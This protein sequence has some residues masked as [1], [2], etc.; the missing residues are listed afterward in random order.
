MLRRL[1]GGDGEVR[2]IVRTV[3]DLDALRS[4]QPKVAVADLE[5]VEGVALMLHDAHT[6]IHLAGGTDLP[7][8]ESY[9]R[10]NLSTAEWVLQACEDAGVRRFLYLSSAGASP[11]AR[12]PYL[13]AKGR[14]EAAVEASTIPER[15]VLRS[16]HVYGPGSAWLAA[17]RAL[18]TAPVAVVP[19]DGSAR[20]APVH[21]DDV[22]AVL[23]AADDRRT[24]VTGTFGLQG[25][26][27]LTVDSL[28]ALLAGRA[29]RPVHVPP[30]RAAR[31]ARLAR[32]ELSQPM[33]EL[34]A[35]DSVRDAP[36][37]AA[38]FGIALTPLA[39][40]LARSG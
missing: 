15:V 33:L 13:R 31:L 40:G 28:V 4:I 35:K 23:A 25:P 30:A 17:L 36:D 12:N 24:A 21:V 34:L 7:D 32:R 11:D 6:V 16:T 19:G 27:E 37:A 5:D 9:E 10:A 39:D 38:E 29:R 2:G 18:A 3:R 1:A 14:A 8:A 22:T 20:V 26:D